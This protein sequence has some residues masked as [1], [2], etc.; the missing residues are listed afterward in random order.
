MDA[1]AEFLSAEC[2]AALRDW[3]DEHMVVAQDSKDAITK[4]AVLSSIKHISP[5]SDLKTK[6]MEDTLMRT[7]RVTT[8]KGIRERIKY[9]WKGGDLVYIKANSS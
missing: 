3:L 9:E 4:T 1:T 8:S 7:C 6:E 2:A 5:F